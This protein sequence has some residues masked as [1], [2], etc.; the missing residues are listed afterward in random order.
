ML[1]I[2]NVEV[3]GWQ[4]ALRGMR[5]PYNSWAKSDTGD[6]E[7]PVLGE[8]DLSLAE[9]LAKAGTDHGKF[10]RMINVYAD[11]TAPW[12]WW[13]EFDTYRCGVE[14]NS[15]SSMHNITDK[16]FTL[17]DFSFEHLDSKSVAV[18][19]KVLEILNLYRDDFNKS[20][21]KESWW[22]IIQMIPNSYDQKRTVMMNYA[23][24]RNMYHARKH[25]KLDE[26]H[27]FCDWVETLP[28][29]ELITADK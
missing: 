26:W 29:S 28:F 22:Q 20:K 1:T 7:T 15:C 17:D 24:L 18:M 8:N 3:N 5:N 13:K 16:P 6:F 25:H 19:E 11:I 14:K 9:K 2:S 21:N 10:L 4:P 27:T 23:S 12:Y